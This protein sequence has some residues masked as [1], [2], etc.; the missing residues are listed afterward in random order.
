MICETDLASL[1]SSRGVPAY[2]RDADR[3]GISARQS[4][5]RQSKESGR[6]PSPVPIDGRP[7]PG[8]RE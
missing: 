2:S 7:P 3:R 8:R 4:R 5:D 6:N 1:D